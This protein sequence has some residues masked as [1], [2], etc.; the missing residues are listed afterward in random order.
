MLLTFLLLPPFRDELMGILEGVLVEKEVDPAAIDKGAF[1]EGDSSYCD[2]LGD[3]P[4]EG[5][6]DRAV[7]S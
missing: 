5:E 3:L 6:G 1:G 7:N 2:I 4:L